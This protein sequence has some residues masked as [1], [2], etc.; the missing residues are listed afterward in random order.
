METE[1]AEEVIRVSR[2][3]MRLV[4]REVVELIDSKPV[5]GVRQAAE[6]EI[7][8]EPVRDESG[9][10]VVRDGKPLLHPAPQIEE[11]DE[12]RIRTKQRAALDADGNPV[13]RLGVRYDQLFVLVLAVLFAERSVTR[14][15]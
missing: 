1:E 15:G 4:D 5:L 9:K 3:K 6:P 14:L 7:A 13:M 12:V 11:I 10:P 8:L 2:P